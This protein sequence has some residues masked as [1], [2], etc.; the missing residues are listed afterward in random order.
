MK[1]RAGFT[2]VELLVVIAIIG[3]LVAL[4]LP[5]VQAAREAARRSQC[6]NN[7]RQV[8]LGLMGF[9]DSKKAFPAGRMGCDGNSVTGYDGVNCAVRTGPKNFDLAISGASAMAQILPYMEQQALYRLLHIDEYP[10]WSPTG[11]ASDWLTVSPDIQQA[12]AQRPEMMLCP[13]DGDMK[14]FADYNHSIP[15][16]YSA[17]TGSY[18]GVG[19]STPAADLGVLKYGDNGVFMYNRM[20]TIREITDGLS[21]TMVAGETISG[22]GESPDNGTTYYNNNIWTNGNRWN[23]IRS[24]ANPLNFPLGLDGGGGR[25]TSAAPVQYTNGAFASRHPGG[26]IFVFGDAHASLVP[27]GID[28]IV[29]KALST[30]AGDEVVDG[31][32]L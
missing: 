19:G 11:G 2:L 22:H 21:N 31:N 17:A 3:V 1:R 25:C 27:E 24:T 28:T 26:A 18:A 5:A 8:G 12:I 23:S 30:R 4:L 7:L 29:Y 20:V 10:I 9:E 14:Q 6:I 15:S 13:S 16:R 32:T